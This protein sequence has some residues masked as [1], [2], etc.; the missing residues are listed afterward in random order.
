VVQK[1]CHGAQS[2]RLDR[3]WV[4]N[5]YSDASNPSGR[6]ELSDSDDDDLCG[7]D[8]DS[9]LTAKSDASAK[10]LSLI[11]QRPQPPNE[12]LLNAVT[13]LRDDIPAQRRRWRRAAEDAAA[14]LQRFGFAAYVHSSP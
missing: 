3:A 7:D 12:A 14:H 4:D 11:N 9:A 1:T 13:A 2:T 10:L 8:D 6:G 5:D